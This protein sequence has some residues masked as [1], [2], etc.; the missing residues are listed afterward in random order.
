MSSN[1]A[2]QERYIK[3]I[4]IEN[5]QSHKL[6]EIIPGGPGQMT[7]IVGQSRQGKTAIFRALKWLFNNSPD[8]VE[9]I[10]WGANFAR[11]TVEYSDDIL[12]TRYRT[13]GGV[14]RY[15]VSIFADGTEQVYEGFGRGAVPLEVRQITGIVEVEIGEGLTL[16]LNMAEQ[17]DGPFLGGKSTSGTA[18]AKV[19]GKL[20]GTEEVDLAGKLLGTDLYRWRRDKES[21]EK[22]IIENKTKLQ[23][24]EYLPGLKEKVNKLT[25]IIAAVKADT[26]R[27]DK[28]EQARMEYYSVAMQANDARIKMLKCRDLVNALEPIGK[29]VDDFVQTRARADQVM[30]EWREIV[31]SILD[32]ETV[33]EQT[34]A[35]SR[36]KNE[37]NKTEWYTTVNRQISGLLTMWNELENALAQVSDI[38]CKTANI[39][40]ARSQVDKADN[41][42][43]AKSKMTLLYGQWGYTKKDIDA[44]VRR[45]NST[46]GIAEAAT[47]IEQTRNK[48]DKRQALIGTNFSLYE[49]S[50]KRTE[51]LSFMKSADQDIVSLSQN[52][53][54]I[55]K[56]AGKCPTCGSEISEGSKT[57]IREVI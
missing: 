52:Y 46:S 23:G 38:L 53:Y 29:A 34:Q 45:V 27:R 56:Q 1:I 12:V 35:I 44:V 47:I 11:V 32:A 14:N 21:H 10:R 55:L 37:V 39:S 13:R 33:L 41:Q 25:G 20:A 9:F 18:R 4:I 31:A 48:A 5:F 6:T 19:L 42:V 8:G 16:N 2:L 49:I 36:A 30:A 50:R 51:E 28:L 40:T 57:K 15:I 7:V 54:E 22:A 26:E 3:R 17:L 24:Y 43:N